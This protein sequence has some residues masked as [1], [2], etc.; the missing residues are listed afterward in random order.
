MFLH[1]LN[2]GQPKGG[3]IFHYDVA[4][5]IERKL[6]LGGIIGTRL[7]LGIMVWI[8]EIERTDFAAILTVVKI[9]IRKNLINGFSPVPYSVFFGQE[10]WTRVYAAESGSDAQTDEAAQ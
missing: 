6:S 3:R 1:N 2:I 9:I 4:L 7:D 8:G 5:V 10:N